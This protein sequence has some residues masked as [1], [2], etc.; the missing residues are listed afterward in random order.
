MFCNCIIVH[1]KVLE[2][3]KKIVKKEHNKR[4]CPKTKDMRVSK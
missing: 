3:P 2:T 1:K 4:V